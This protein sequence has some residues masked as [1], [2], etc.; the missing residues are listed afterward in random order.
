MG[1]GF[2][3]RHAV[4]WG[5]KSKSF[6]KGLARILRTFSIEVGPV[7][8]TGAPAMLVAMTGVIVGAGIA[9][10]LTRASSQLPESLRE[11]KGLINR[12]RNDDPAFLNP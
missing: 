2:D 1:A 3:G 8:A 7:R 4:L 12:F 11:A 5:V 6:L 10:A 9:T